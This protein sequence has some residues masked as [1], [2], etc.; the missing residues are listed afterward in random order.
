MWVL[1]ALIKLHHYYLC[2][3]KSIHILN[4]ILE[5]LKPKNLDFP[6]KTAL[7]SLVDTQHTVWMATAQLRPA[8]SIS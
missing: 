3:Q 7:P 1:E 8:S 2:R 6:E 5:R 4:H